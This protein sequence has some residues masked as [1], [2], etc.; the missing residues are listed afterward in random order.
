LELSAGL[1]IG[2][3]VKVHLGDVFHFDVEIA[4]ER[5]DVPEYVSEF[6]RDEFSII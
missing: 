4:A 3:L 1:A 5:S 2:Q 6:L